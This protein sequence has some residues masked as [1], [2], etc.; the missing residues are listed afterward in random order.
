MTL[1]KGYKPYF[2]RDLSINIGKLWKTSAGW[3]MVTLGKDYYDFH[4]DSTDDIRKIW[5]AGTVSLEPGLLRFSQWAKDFKYLA[6]K[7]TH[8]SL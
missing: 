3:K 7:Q 8:V 6:Q 2:A 4:F 5:A 1:N